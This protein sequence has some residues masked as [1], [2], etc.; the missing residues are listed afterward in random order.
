MLGNPSIFIDEA[1]IAR[2]TNEVRIISREVYS[3]QKL[4]N[5]ICITP[6]RLNAGHPLY[7]W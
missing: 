1:K 7:G 3:L 5:V 6:Q 2:K 4:L